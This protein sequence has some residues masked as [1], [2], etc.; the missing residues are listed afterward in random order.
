MKEILVRYI[1]FIGILLLAGMLVTENILLSK[2]LNIETI[3]KLAKIDAVYGLSAVITFIAGMLLWLVV[4]KPSQF[5]TGN[6]VFHAK[7]G[8]FV[9]IAILSI[10]PTIF[11]LKNQKFQAEKLIVPSHILLIKRT[12]LA[13][14]LVL[15][16][17]AIHMARGVGNA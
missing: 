3:K 10:F 11:F 15:P 2:Q 1:H 13:L 9:V 14:L 16:L 17:L 4:G 6:A 7:L 5:Y 12:E 8:L